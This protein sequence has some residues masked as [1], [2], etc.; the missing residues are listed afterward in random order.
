MSEDV[1]QPDRKRQA[2]GEVKPPSHL[3]EILQKVLDPERQDQ[4]GSHGGSGR[5][6]SIHLTSGPCS[7]STGRG[8]TG[9]EARAEPSQ[10][11]DTYF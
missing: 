10:R 6:Q 2:G 1:F 5:G 4:D 11:S 3:R 9:D 7:G 8:P